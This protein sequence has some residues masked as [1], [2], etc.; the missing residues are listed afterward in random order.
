MDAGIVKEEEFTSGSD[1]CLDRTRTSCLP[2]AR[3]AVTIYLPKAGDVRLP[4][5]PFC[6]IKLR[7]GK[8][9]GPGHGSGSKVAC[10]DLL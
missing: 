4:H 10:H 6:G 3:R 8:W 9:K 1:F 7:E 5:E 2:V